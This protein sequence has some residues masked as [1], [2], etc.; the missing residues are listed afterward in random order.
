VKRYKLRT[1]VRGK[2]ERGRHET[3]P[4]ALDALAVRAAELARDADEAPE[5]GGIMRRIEPVQQVIGRLEVSGPHQLHAGVD[6]RGDGSTEAWT[7]QL[8]R[9]VIQQQ[10]GEDAVAALRRTLAATSR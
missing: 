6:V 10:D 5:G 4:D 8:R 2:V 1:R 3:L 7:G 9:E